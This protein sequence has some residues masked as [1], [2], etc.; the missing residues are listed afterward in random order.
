ML[1]LAFAA[2]LASLAGCLIVR[3]ALAQG[4]QQELVDRATLAA[5]DMLNNQNGRDAQAMLR[6]SK[7]V[8]ICPRILQAGFLFG[9]QGG[10]CVMTGKDGHGHWSPPAFYG[11][12]GAS[13]GFQAGL[14]DVSV[15]MFVLNPRGVMALMDNQFKL[16]A[17][18]GATFVEW[19][20]GVEGATTAALNADIV[21]FSRA[22][23]LFAGISL[24]GSIISPRTEWNERY[25]GHILAGQQIVL[26]GEGQ[27]IGAAPLREVLARAERSAEGQMPV[28]NAAPGP[29]YSPA[30]PY[31][32][33]QPAGYGAVQATPLAPPV[34]R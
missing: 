4:E 25:Y 8:L 6:R 5:Q 26:N 31:S 2:C 9:A 23:G 29:G 17:D 3:P 24:G 16:G 33:P 28:A 14:Q 30:P 20:G 34:R 21:S 32:P 12:G 13:F 19:G 11:I 15:M 18:A 7:A 10:G 27:N 1:R 22:R